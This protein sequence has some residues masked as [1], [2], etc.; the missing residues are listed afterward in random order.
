MADLYV[1]KIGGN[2]IDNE[3]KLTSFLSCFA[4]L[5]AAKILI[6]GG[7]KLATRLAQ[8]MNVEQQIVDGRRI[9]DAETLKIVT[10]VYAGEINK[11]I[12]A[13]LQQLNCN[14]LGLTGTDG[15][16][17]QSHKRKAA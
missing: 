7:G 15:N 13:R 14:A 8:Q 17:I 4:S 16:L 1:I 3:E 12:V 11:T 5:K 2:I 10:M 9:T 6:H